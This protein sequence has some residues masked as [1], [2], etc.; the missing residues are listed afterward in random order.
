MLKKGQIWPISLDI[1]GIYALYIKKSWSK[2]GT[3]I[4]DDGQIWIF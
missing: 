4:H 2:I 1:L 3:F